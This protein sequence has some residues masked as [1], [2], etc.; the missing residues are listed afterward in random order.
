[1]PLRAPTPEVVRVVGFPLLW[2]FVRRVNRI[3]EF[4]PL[5]FF[6]WFRDP[7]QNALEGGGRYSQ[8]LA[9]LAVDVFPRQGTNET[10]VDAARAVGLVPIDERNHV[11]IQAFPAS[12]EVVRR[13]FSSLA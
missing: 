6:S 5:T 11:H 1:M 7:L 9:A 8:H 3:D 4:E 12:V 10:V 13:F 2:E